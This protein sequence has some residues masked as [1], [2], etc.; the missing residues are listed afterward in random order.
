[1]GQ[2]AHQDFQ[3]ISLWELEAEQVLAYDNPALLPFVPLM[4]GGNTEQMVRRCADRIR[5]EPKALELETILSVFAGYVLETELIKQ[6]LRWEMEVIKESPI[7]QELYQLGFEEGREK[8]REE[9]QRKAILEVLYQILAIRFDVGLGEFEKRFERLDLESLK[10]LNE[11][12]L[13]AQTLV[14]FENTLA[15]VLSNVATT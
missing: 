2:A 15:D 9:G 14:E 1:M 5:R 3:V 8:G 4:Q 12:A 10:R 11:A 7:I 6:I 13:T